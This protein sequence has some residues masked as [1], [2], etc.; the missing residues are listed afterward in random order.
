M[1]ALPSAAT[2]RTTFLPA[3]P[4]RFPDSHPTQGQPTPT[5]PP[6]KVTEV[7]EQMGLNCLFL[8]ELG[9][10]FEGQSST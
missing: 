3:A 7:M 5:N 9:G 1:G 2:L 8:N 10:I 6:N 4:F